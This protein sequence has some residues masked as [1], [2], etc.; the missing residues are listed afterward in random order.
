MRNTLQRL[1]TSL[2]L[3]FEWLQA[4]LLFAIRITIARVF[5]YSGLTKIESW[6]STLALFEYEYQVP[7]IPVE[8]AATLATTAEIA[9]PVLLVLGL[10]TRFAAIPLLAITAVIQF[11]YLES[12]EHAYWA[13]L[14]LTIISFGPKAWSLDHW[15]K[16]RT[17]VKS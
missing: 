14:L 12:I 16:K 13:L 17:L 7:V 6:D 15:I 10:G 3:G 2:I 9:C 8:L 5:F 1:I 11:T 4:P